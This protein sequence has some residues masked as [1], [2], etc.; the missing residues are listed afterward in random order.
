M[1]CLPH[2]PRHFR[3]HIL[4]RHQLAAAPKQS[5]PANAAAP[6]GG[7]PG[8]RKALAVRT[9]GGMAAAD[10][11]DSDVSPM[12]LSPSSATASAAEAAQRAA[13]RKV[14][15]TLHAG[16]G[17]KKPVGRPARQQIPAAGV[18]KAAAVATKAAF[19]KRQDE[20]DEEEDSDGE[21][22]DEE[23]HAGLLLS[24]GI[25]EPLQLF[26]LEAAMTEALA[27]WAETGGEGQGL[28]GSEQR[29]DRGLKERHITATPAAVGS[30]ALVAY[31]CSAE[32]LFLPHPAAARLQVRTSSASCCA[33]WRRTLCGPRQL[34][35]GQQGRR[36][37][38]LAALLE[39]AVLQ[40]QA[41]A[42]LLRVLR[43]PPRAPRPVRLWRPVARAAV[44]W[45]CSASLR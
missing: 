21:G 43:A 20:S 5:A 39:R 25:M 3:C 29:N 40:P 37:R 18:G 23:L 28:S 22:A 9:A 1:R 32:A 35:R 4:H 45:S 34:R 8:S 38:Q 15:A 24:G 30:F 42:S 6:S 19:G 16:K 11:D 17:S 10:D 36:Q 27:Q 44:H 31:R 2:S 41:R 13:G 12:S 26:D 33:C 14:A 7:N